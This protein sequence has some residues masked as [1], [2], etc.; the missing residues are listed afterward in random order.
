M[1]P[2]V[3]FTPIALFA[4]DSTISP[5]SSQPF[6][7]DIKISRL[8]FKSSNEYDFEKIDF[9]V[10]ALEHC[11]ANTSSNNKADYAIVGIMKDIVPEFISNSSKYSSIDVE[12]N[13]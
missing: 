6:S 7:P 3:K 9:Q 4:N 2:D 11:L 8:A 13:K 10:M 1:E 12:R 5:D